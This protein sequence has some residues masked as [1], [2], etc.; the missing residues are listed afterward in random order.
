MDR[1]IINDNFGISV[2]IGKAINPISQTN[3]EGTGIEPCV[4][5]PEKDA[6]AK[7][8]LLAID[9][10]AGKTGDEKQKE[11]YNWISERLNVKLNP[12]TLDSK[13]LEKYTGTYGPRIITSENGSL[14]YQREGRPKYKMVPVSETLFMFEELE[15]FMLEIVVENG[16]GAALI[17]HYDDG[18]TDRNERTR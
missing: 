8:H 11:A 10:L 4:H 13:L 16:K 18:R 1:K 5:V 2:P 7:A 9:S 12:V 3:W 17:G 14:Y 6:L 15:Y